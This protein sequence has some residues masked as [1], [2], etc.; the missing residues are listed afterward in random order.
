MALGFS[1]GRMAF[2]FWVGL[3]VDWQCIGSGVAVD[4]QRIGSGLAVDWQWIG[5]GLAVDQQRIGS[6]L[7]VDWRWIGGGLAVD[8]PRRRENVHPRP[9]GEHFRESWQLGLGCD[10]QASRKWLPQA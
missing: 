5:S 7:A 1:K 3:A 10:S 2:D 4:W 8:C 9:E 6:E